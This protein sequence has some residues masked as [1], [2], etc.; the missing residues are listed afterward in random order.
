VGSDASQ[1]PAC[2]RSVPRDVRHVTG[3][4]RSHRY[5]AHPD[6][7]HLNRSLSKVRSLVREDVWS[8]YS[9]EGRLLSREDAIAAGIRDSL[10]NPNGPGLSDADQQSAN[11]DKSPYS[12]A[13]CRSAEQGDISRAAAGPEPIQRPNVDGST[14]RSSPQSGPSVYKT[15]ADGTVRASPT[16]TRLLT[17]ISGATGRPRRPGCQRLTS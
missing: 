16:P 14:H 10:S 1:D 7:A 2:T 17:L 12:A 8:N 5:E 6:A 3:Q 4:L 9:N 13:S 15:A 11:G